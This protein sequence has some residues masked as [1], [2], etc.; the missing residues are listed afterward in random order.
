LE[1]YAQNRP[2]LK[3]LIPERIEAYNRYRPHFSCSMLT[4]EQMHRQQKIKI[5]KYSKKLVPKGT[6]GD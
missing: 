3:I 6:L 1:K 2:V 4:P 5:K